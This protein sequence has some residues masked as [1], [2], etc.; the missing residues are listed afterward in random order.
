MP[1]VEKMRSRLDFLFDLFRPKKCPKG[2]PRR[3]LLQ[4]QQSVKYSPFGLDG[5]HFDCVEKAQASYFREHWNRLGLDTY[6]DHRLQLCMMN[7]VYAEVSSDDITSQWRTPLK[8]SD[9]KSRHSSAESSLEP[10]SDRAGL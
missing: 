6:E 5:L 10:K 9:L 4:L 3:L 8:F 2:L 1:T 7:Q